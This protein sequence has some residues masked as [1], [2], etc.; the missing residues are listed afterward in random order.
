MIRKLLDLLVL[1][2]VLTIAAVTLRAS[3]V[4]LW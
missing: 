1:A 3:G 2:A 4:P